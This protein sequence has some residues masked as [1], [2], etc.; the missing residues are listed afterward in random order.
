M[1]LPCAEPQPY[2]PSTRI[3]L[4]TQT[5]IKERTLT[6]VEIFS[7]THCVLF[8]ATASME[9]MSYMRTLERSTK[10]ASCA[11]GWANGMFSKFSSLGD[12]VLYIDMNL[13]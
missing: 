13:T 2:L 1:Y 11:R 3:V 10:S 12:T 8:V 9:V 5:K 4:K 7:S 6:V